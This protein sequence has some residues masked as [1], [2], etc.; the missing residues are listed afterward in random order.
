MIEHAIDCVCSV[1]GARLSVA[2][3]VTGAEGPLSPGD[4]VVCRKCGARLVF[5]DARKLRSLT[6]AE[7]FVFGVEVKRAINAARRAAMTGDEGMKVDLTLLAA[8]VT[9]CS[10]VEVLPW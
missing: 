8:C 7:F 2:V 10:L 5:D 4:P 9:L 3:I 1:C 6:P